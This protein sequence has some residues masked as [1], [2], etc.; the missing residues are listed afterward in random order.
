MNSDLEKNKINLAT[1]LRE[2]NKIAKKLS[3][4]WKLIN[5][6]NAV[7]AGN[8][9]PF[10]MEHKLEEAFKLKD[11]LVKIKLAIK[12]ANKGID[13]HLIEIAELRSEIANL[14]KID[15]R[16]GQVADRYG[17]EMVTYDSEI[18]QVK[19]LDL[20]EARESQIDQLQDAVNQFNY[21]TKIE[22]EF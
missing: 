4:I 13:K 10:N 20:I 12:N 2:K 11:Q 9:R 5:Q 17:R 7:I 15:T 3:E 16:E 1:A 18:K 14:R 8:T 19:V 22:F 21:D 6:H